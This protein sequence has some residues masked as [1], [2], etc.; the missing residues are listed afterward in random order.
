MF[1]ITPR[2]SSIIFIP[3]H[4]PILKGE[5][6]LLVEWDAPWWGLIAE[7]TFL[8]FIMHMVIKIFILSEWGLFWFNCGYELVQSLQNTLTIARHT[9]SWSGG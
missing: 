9:H 4:Y 1:L 8:I 7:G 5:V 2:S 3:W 6:R